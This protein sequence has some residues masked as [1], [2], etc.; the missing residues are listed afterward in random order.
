M[1]RPIG[2]YEDSW[3][4]DLTFQEFDS[5][6]V[7]LIEDAKNSAARLVNLLAEHFP[8]FNDEGV[9]ER[10]KVRLLKR[11]QIFVADLWA[12]FDGESYGDFNDIDKITMFAGN[13][14]SR[15]PTMECVYLTGCRLPC[16]A[17]A[18]FTR[19]HI[20]LSAA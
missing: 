18:T 10:K 2:I 11:A 4:N 14:I 15:S 7:V 6:V 16:S 9:F 12:A 19:V 1:A 5:S 20:I 17:N 8:C 13:I 3:T